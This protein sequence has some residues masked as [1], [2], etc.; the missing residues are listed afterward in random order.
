MTRLRFVAALVTLTLL[1]TR[2]DAAACSCAGGSSLDDELAGADA[3]FVARV[4]AVKRRPG[5]QDV[6][7]TVTQ[8]FK[9]ARK[10]ASITVRTGTGGGDCGIP[11][12]AARSWL[13][14]ASRSPQLFI[15]GDPTYVGLF[16]IPCSRTAPAE[17]A[18]PD[19]EAL[20][21]STGT[22]KA[23][24]PAPSPAPDAPPSLPQ[25]ETAPAS[26][27]PLDPPPPSPAPST[28]PPSPEPSGSGDAPPAASGAMPASPRGARGCACDVGPAGGAGGLQAALLALACLAG[29]RRRDRSREHGS[30]SI[31]DQRSAAPSSRRLRTPSRR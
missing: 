10:G 5:G 6:R 13:V 31:E 26:S 23:K 29:A 27:A 7:L 28:V 17:R 3:V 1:L 15:G 2:G 16:T 18:K 12:D 11:F 22:T 19:I 21:G 4:D 30:G 9:G 24:P 14:F 20:A 25:E 8:A